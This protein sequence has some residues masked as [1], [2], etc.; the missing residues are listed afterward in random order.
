[1]SAPQISRVGR[2]RPLLDDRLRAKALEAVYSI[3]R[4]LANRA[5]KDASLAGGKAGLAI[6]YSYL[7]KARSGCGDAE[8]A[9]R[10][11]DQAGDAVS[12]TRMSANLFGGFTGVAWTMAY[13]QKRL[14]DSDTEDPN[15]S[16]DEA[17]KFIL[18]GRPGVITTISSLG[19]SA[20]VFTRWSDCRER[21][22]STA[23]N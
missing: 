4:S 3:A 14:L 21:T 15:G 2:W 13:L 22:P 8:T 16:I 12:A 20:L 19:W 6:F 10:F 18:G 7:A 1:M 9:L 11:L 17:L 23:W 5:G